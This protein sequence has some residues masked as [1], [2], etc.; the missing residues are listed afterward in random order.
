MDILHTVFTYCACSHNFQLIVTLQ[1]Y[2]IW[3]VYQ[4]HWLRLHKMKIMQIASLFCLH[5]AVEIQIQ[6]LS[7]SCVCILGKTNNSNHL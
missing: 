4:I 1:L 2:M 5:H 3:K 7:T 6:V